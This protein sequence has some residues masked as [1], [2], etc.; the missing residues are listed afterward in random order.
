MDARATRGRVPATGASTSTGCGVTPAP[1]A[2]RAS[3]SRP[4]R[5]PRCSRR[6]A[7]PTT[8]RSGADP[9]VGA[10]P[11]RPWP[12][13]STRCRRS[14]SARQLT[15][16]AD[17]ATVRFYFKGQLIKTHPR[18]PPGGR[19]TD[20]NDFPPEKLAYA[21]ARHRL[22]AVARPSARPAVGR[23]AQALLDGPL[24]WTRMRRVYALL[25]L[26]RRFGK[27]RVDEACALA[28]ASEMLDVLAPATHARSWPSAA[29]PPPRAGQRRAARALPAPG[30][31]STPSR[32]HP[33]RRPRTHQ[34]RNR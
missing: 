30:A 8:C 20:P 23:F 14:T 1:S 34:E 11:A 13:R 25:G 7:S 27:E 18:K 29:R 33:A 17:R 15:A 2:C 24:P 19:S 28:L 12:R 21:H 4:R 32:S 31:R 26:C 3:T 10:R 5:R 22:P 9:T 6:P 16:R